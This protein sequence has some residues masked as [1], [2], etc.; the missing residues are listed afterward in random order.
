MKKYPFVKQEGVKDCGVACL[1]MIV[2]HYKG[3]VNYEHLIDMTKTNKN[4]TTALNII[5]AAKSL[6]FKAS[7]IKTSLNNKSFKDINLPCIAH[8]IINKTY[9]HYVVIYKIDHKNKNLLVAD[10]SD[11]IKRISFEKFEKIWSGVLILMYPFK[12]IP[13]LDHKVS[14]FSLFTNIISLFKKDIILLILMS[15]F[16]TIFS[17][18][19]SFYFKSLIDQ[20]TD[21][22]NGNYL[23]MIFIVFTCCYLLKILTN[24]FR[25][26]VLIYTNQKIDI[27][28]A[29]STFK[30]IILFPYHY[31]R[32]RTTGEIVSRINDI[33][34]IR[35]TVSRIIVTVFIDM[36][37]TIISLIVLFV[38]NFNLALIAVLIFIINIVLIMIFQHIFGLQIEECKLAKDET[39]S[40]MIETISGFET[41]KGL[42]VEDKI[43]KNFNHKYWHQ[44]AKIKHFNSTYNWQQLFKELIN[45]IGNIIILFV[46]IHL[47]LENHLT[48]GS[49]IA[50]ASLLN[51]F[52]EPVQN[53][54]EFATDIKEIKIVFRRVGEL[55]FKEEK[56]NLNLINQIKG[57]IVI[58][59]LNYSYDNNSMILQ[60][61]NFKINK[62]HKVIVLGKSGSGKSTLF[63]IIMKYYPIERNQLYIDG[64]DINDINI[65]KV[66]HSIT[67][68]SQNEMLFTDTVYNNILLSRPCHPERLKKVLNICHIQDII[69][70]EQLGLNTLVEE[71]G[72]NFSGGEK[73]R[74]VLARSLIKTFNILII[75]EGLNQIDVNLERQILKKLFKTYSDKTII[76]IS[77]RHDNIDLYDQMIAFEA[78]RKVSSVIKNV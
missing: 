77:H 9:K 42:G 21:I 72:F 47:V 55:G 36:L 68:I 14:S 54:I 15:L 51:Y 11:K 13:I 7:G 39:N 5:E 37:L 53:M 69:Q 12:A 31:Y 38:I 35:E 76:V 49:L 50:F 61:V 40:Y 19:S 67:Y 6:G 27:A 25:N 78:N 74:I 73:Q 75:D 32:N 46:G 22:N 2:Q 56:N 45:E 30:K 66:K 26:Q 71:N 43:I 34:I 28:L 3:Y 17:I 58:K 1:S 59:H 4:G 48:L 41:V 10:P 70:N 24:Y 18:I 8:V 23:N 60:Q 33:N 62:G 20:I 16:I 44:T 29:T 63:K 65:D 52:L 64:V 57:N